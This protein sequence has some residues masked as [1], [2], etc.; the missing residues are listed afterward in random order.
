MSLNADIL[1]DRRRLRRRMQVWR[2]V[3]VCAV[4]LAIIGIGIGTADR[5]GL[6]IGRDHI[7]RYVITGTIQDDLEEQNLLRE[8]GESKS[9]KALILYINSPG[10][11]TAGAEALFDSIRR[12]S[13]TKPVVAVLGT[14]AAS[15]G[16]AVAL[17]ADRIVARGNT[18]TGSI[19]VIMQWAEVADLLEKAGIRVEEVKSGPLKAA[20]SPFKRASSEARAATES[21]VRDSYDWFVGLV[22]DRRSLDPDRARVLS[23]GRVYT[24][25]Q[26]K[27]VKLVDAIGGET[28][29]VKWLQVEKKIQRNLKVVEWTRSSFEDLGLGGAAL[30][31]LLK[32]TGLEGVASV[33]RLSQKTLQTERLN[34]DGLVS[35][36]HPER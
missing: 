25:R 13:E 36:W 6:S 12:V 24:G 3:A 2:V 22:R 29:A 26:A 30:A 18:I 34:L 17:G 23:D 15:A 1:A 5:A 16:Y 27:E 31:W 21:M 7:A 32:A 20:P 4:I 9:A 8:I 35:V 19:G 28:E 10:G 11:T 14:V 33:L